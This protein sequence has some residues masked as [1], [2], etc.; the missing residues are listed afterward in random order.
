MIHIRTHVIVLYDALSV[1]VLL[2]TMLILVHR[3]I[4]ALAFYEYGPDTSQ[5]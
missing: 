4:L 1:Y 5:T 2:C 3:M